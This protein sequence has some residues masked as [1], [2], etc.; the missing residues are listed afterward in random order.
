ME[1]IKMPKQKISKEKLIRILIWVS[2]IAI[3]FIAIYALRLIAAKP[4]GNISNAF[5]SVFIPFAIAF[6]LSF[7]IGPFAS[8]IENKLKMKRG[9]SIVLAI[10]LG[11]SV[12]IGLLTFVIVNLVVQMSSIFSSLINMID[13]VWLENIVSVVETY[14]QTYINDTELAEILNQLTSNGLSVDR[15]IE[16][17]GGIL[18]FLS[19]LT[20]SIFQAVMILI[21]TPVF[22]FY[23]IKEKA[24]IFNGINS[25][26]PENVQ[27]HLE[28]LGTRTDTLVR[29][30]L[31]G[32]GIMIALIATYFSIFLSI[33]SFF[34]PGFSIQMAILFALIMGLFNIVPYIGAWIGLSLPVLFMFTLHLESVQNNEAKSIFVIGILIVVVLQVVEQVI[35][36]SVVQPQ[37][38]GNKVQIHPLLVLSSLIFFGGIFGFVG[39]LLAVPLAATLKSSLEYFKS[40]NNK[41]PKQSTT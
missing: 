39:V 14:V 34:I 16:L 22:L 20:S 13:A 38:L 30:Y 6:F 7:I 23:L 17:L 4:L 36:A 28:A 29:N 37:V 3:S 31:K 26:F 25:V 8:L 9:I 32:Q 19:N 24:Y 33:L 2:I 27:P 40:L 10:I 35:E 5:K 21:L 11:L 18:G 1:D 15:V 12:I 41:K